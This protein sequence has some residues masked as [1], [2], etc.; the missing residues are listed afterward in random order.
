MGGA[1]VA[2]ISALFPA[3]LAADGCS[4]DRGRLAPLLLVPLGSQQ[5]LRLTLLV[6]PRHD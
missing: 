1:A 3:A 4:I 5:C 2:P 6:S